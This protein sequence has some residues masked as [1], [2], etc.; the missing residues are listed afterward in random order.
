[1]HGFSVTFTP[2]VLDGAYIHR[3]RNWAEEL[4]REVHRRQWGAVEDIDR[5]T[6]TVWVLAASPKVTGDLAKEIH[7]SLRRGNLLQ[8]ATVRKLTTTEDWDEYAAFAPE[9]GRRPTRR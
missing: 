6:D 9:A 8:D 5:S 3:V 4:F 2:P 1:V 7:R